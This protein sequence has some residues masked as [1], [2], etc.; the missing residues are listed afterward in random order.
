ME[1]KQYP[2]IVAIETFDDIEELT[3]LWSD[4]KHVPYGLTV[5]LCEGKIVKNKTRKQK[6]IWRKLLQERN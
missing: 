1:P 3:F 6:L 5:S 4:G 2:A